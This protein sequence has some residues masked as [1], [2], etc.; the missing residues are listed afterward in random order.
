MSACS[1]SFF[2]CLYYCPIFS[3]YL[4][5]LFVYLL[6]EL[7]EGWGENNGAISDGMTFYLKHLGSTLVEELPEGDSYGDG[8]SSKAV[9]SIVSMVSTRGVCLN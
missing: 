3:G 5:T 2:I 7:P 4:P 8:I 9:A 1:P 6:S